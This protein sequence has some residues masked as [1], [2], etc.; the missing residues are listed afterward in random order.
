[1]GMSSFR[2]SALSNSQQKKGGG[3]GGNWKDVY[4]LP[5][6][7]ATPF[8]LIN[9]E[10]IDPSPSPDRVEVG[11]NGQPLPVKNAFYKYRSH[12]RKMFKNGKERFAMETCSQGYDPHN[13][14]PCAGCMAM[15]LGD[16]TVS[17]GD[18]FAFA[19]VHLVPYH[20]HPQIDYENG[21]YKTDKE[22]KP[23][24]TFS[25]CEGRTCNFC[26]ILT[27][28]PPIRRKEDKY[29]FPNY[30]PAD[31][32]T[33]FG[34]RRYIEIGKSHLSNLEA[35]DGSITNQCSAHINDAAGN[36]LARCA[37]QLTSESWNCPTCGNVVIDM[38]SDPRSDEE[39]SQAVAHPYPCLHC[40]KAVLLSEVT[41]CDSCAQ[42]GRDM[43]QL[44]LF[45]VV[46]WGKRHGEG[47]KSQ[48]VLHK[49]QTVDEFQK[50]LPP[51][52]V[53][54]LQGKSIFDTIKDLAKPYDFDKFLGPKTLEEQMK[55]M[56]LSFSM[57]GTQQPSAYGTQPQTTPQA[58]YV[59]PWAT[60]PMEV[61]PAAG[62]VV[63]GAVVA[64]PLPPG[65]VPYAPYPPQQTPQHT[66][67]GPQGFQ[68][69]MK[70]NFSK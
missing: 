60:K 39:I 29:D 34:H 58:P 46:L 14:K 24:Y 53:S 40:Q 26:R 63:E 33:E 70:P 27:G 65:A 64:P 69:P 62:Q 9:A 68:M 31:V 57:P 2:R 6:G 30:N 51:G 42:S 5:Q 20:R 8:V 50:T 67:P 35:W 23:Y 43:L 32:T 15:D 59:P 48:L 4:K 16:K 25:E 44:G 17:V 21:K 56:E 36:L 45:D 7:E 38:S 41:S 47:T 22:G 11:P 13:P 61:N 3:S 19:L 1:M 54:L 52:I 18:K 66:L 49:F 55:R 37:N 28:N 12:T 10:Y